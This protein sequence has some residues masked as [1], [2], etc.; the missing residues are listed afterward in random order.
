MPTPKYKL[1]CQEF[2]NT[3]SSSFGLLREEKEL[4]DVTLVSENEDLVSAHKIVLSTSSRFFK[5]L[6]G[7]ISSSNRPS[8]IYLGGVDTKNLHYVLDYIY[9]GEKTK[10]TK[11][12]KSN[13]K[14]LILKQ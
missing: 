10:L 11:V 6:F 3:V 9:R 5:S 1:K 7:K 14:R 2:K 12:I 13:K 8:V 4:C